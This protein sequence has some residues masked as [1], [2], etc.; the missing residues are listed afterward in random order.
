MFSCYLLPHTITFLH[1]RIMEVSQDSQNS[2]AFES[3]SQDPSNSGIVFSACRSSGD[4]LGTGN[5]A[6]GKQRG[7]QGIIVTESLLEF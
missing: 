4:S 5:Q 3:S 2:I 7:A 1:F 6:E